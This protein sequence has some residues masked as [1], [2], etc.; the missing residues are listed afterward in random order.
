MQVNPYGMNYIHYGS[1]TMGP[2][3]QDVPYALTSRSKTVTIPAFYIDIHE[4][5]NNEYR[6]FVYWVRDSLFRDVLQENDF[7]EYFTTEDEQGRELDRF[8][9]KGYVLNWDEPIDWENEDIFDALY[10]EF[11]FPRL[12]PLLRPGSRYPEAELQVLLDQPPGRCPEERIDFEINEP[13]ELGQLNS[14]R[15][16]S[17]RAQFVIEENTNVYPGHP[18]PDGLHL[19]LQRAADGDL[20]LHPAYD[21]YPVVGVTWGQARAFNAWRTQLLATWKRENG[22]TMV[23]KFRLPSEAEWEFAARGG[24]DLAPFPWGGPYIRTSTVARW[25]TSSRCA[26]TTWRMPAATP[27]RSRATAPTTTACTRCPA[28][29]PSGPTP[30]LTKPCTTSATT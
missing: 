3:D 4:I 19:R 28:T 22:E 7:E 10:D 1:Y 5:S 21:D 30:P 26:V 17:D 23:Q 27:C 29:W 24:L 18:V 2:S 9:N 14:V 11:L 13:N 12:R 15:G 8:I 16:H 20:L 25:P 6:Q